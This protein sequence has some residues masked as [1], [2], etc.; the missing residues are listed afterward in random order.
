MCAS[1]VLPSV[2]SLTDRSVCI[3]IISPALFYSTFGGFHHLH[4]CLLVQV[5]LKFCN[6]DSLYSRYWTKCFFL[7]GH[8]CCHLICT[9]YNRWFFFH[10][11][12]CL[13]KYYLFLFHFI[14]V[15]NY[16]KSLWWNMPAYIF[17]YML[18]YSLFL[19]HF[20][21]CNFYEIEMWKIPQNSWW[22]ELWW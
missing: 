11:T 5:S 14:W 9:R 17:D 13:L 6:L 21:V 3:G 7:F 2:T 10:L 22:N 15:S 16:H 4:S 8:F 12:R 19:I 20:S 1:W 18:T